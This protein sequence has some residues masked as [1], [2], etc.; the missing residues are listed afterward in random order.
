MAIPGDGELLFALIGELLFPISCITIL[1]KPEA[2]GN[3]ISVLVW[4][5]Y[6][7]WNYKPQN[8]PYIKKVVGKDCKLLP[9][10]GIFIFIF[11][12]SISVMFLSKKISPNTK[13]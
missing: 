11:S 10:Q 6:I 5:L 2:A 4:S 13:K 12:T 7:C 8:P 9:G 1:A 3:C